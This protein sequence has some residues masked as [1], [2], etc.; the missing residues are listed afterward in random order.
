MRTS[1]IALTAT[2]LIACEAPAGQSPQQPGQNDRATTAKPSELAGLSKAY[3]ASGCFW[4]VEEIYESVKGVKEVVSGYAGG[5]TES[6]TYHGVGD[7][8]TGH[9]EAVEVYYDPKVISYAD[10]VQVFFSSHDPT[11]MDRQGPDAGTQYRSIA[12]Y[13][14]PDEEKLLRAYITELEQAGVFKAP[15]I[16]EVK[17]FTKFWPAEPEHQ[18]YVCLNPN[19]SYVRNVSVPRFEAFKAKHPELVK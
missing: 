6:P 12:F 11:T 13:Q 10:L 3:F 19:A 9:A 2:L 18:N 7:G 4:C 14:D 16:T 1:I 5:N 15:I 17:P 8:T